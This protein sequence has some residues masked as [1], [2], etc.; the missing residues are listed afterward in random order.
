MGGGARV[1]ALLHL[2][3][4]AQLRLTTGIAAKSGAHQDA[5]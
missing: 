5:N 4:G 1:S 3:A 2:V